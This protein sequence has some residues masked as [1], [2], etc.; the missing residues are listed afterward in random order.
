MNTMIHHQV[1]FT[2]PSIR[3][4][5]RSLCRSLLLGLLLFSGCPNQPDGPDGEQASVGLRMVADGLTA[6]LGIITARDSSGR[7][8][9]IDQIGF[10]RIIG[11]D[12]QLRPEPFL[13]LRARLVEIMPAYDE[14]G[15]LGFAFHPQYADNGRFFVLY[16]APADENTDEVDYPVDSVER[17][18]ELRVSADPDT[19]DATS[20][21]ILFQIAKPQFNHNGGQLAFG[22]TD[23]YLYV[24]IGDGGGA[25]DN[26]AG[27]NPEIGNGQDKST[28]FG[29][30]LR[31][32]VNGGEPYAIP[33]DNPFANDPTAMAEIWAYGLRNPWRFSFDRDDPARMFIADVG[34]DLFEEVNLGHRAANYG[35]FL[36]EGTHCFNPD[37]PTQP[38]S[39]CP[40][41]G[42]DGEALVKPL[43][44]YSHLNDV[45]DVVRTSITGGYIYRGNAIPELAGQYIFGDYSAGFESGDGTLLAAQE[46]DDGTWSVRELRVA[47]NADGRIHRFVRSFGEDDGG[48]LYVL[49]TQNLGPSGATGEVFQLTRPE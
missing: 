22:P 38:A 26:E 41:D 18:S 12:G 8:F 28:L 3:S 5:R 27:H 23:G 21:R 2:N 24:S 30:I 46:N 14:R 49:T 36:R 7:L 17:V 42:A 31:I 37:S 15:L 13:D 40:S 6:P 44:D 19:A 25:N 33:A 48:E 9:V 43:F 11:A 45:G 4:R 35:W 20:E 32:D 29:K 1:A 47:G 39:T 10:V 16:N 34:Q